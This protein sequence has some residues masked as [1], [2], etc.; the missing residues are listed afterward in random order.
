MRNLVQELI[1]NA[2]KMGLYT[3][4]D[5]PSDKLRNALSDYAKSV[6]QEEVLALY[7]ATLLGNAKDG[8]V[9]TA[10]RL[11][12]QNNNLEP[13]QTVRYEDIIHVDT[14]RKLL[15]GRQINLDV[16]R[17]RAT[18]TLTLDFSAKAAA[19]EYVARFLQEALHRSVAAEMDT[20][21]AAAQRTPS[22][23][24]LPVIEQALDELRSSGSLTT[25][26]HERILRVLRG[27]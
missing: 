16:N 9:F 21:P 10:D 15:G 8:A 7:D 1:P 17:G 6:H 24:N 2:P 20:P 5:I 12:F 13:A 14:R 18:V 27:H 23:S 19:A 3:R 4:P 11:V 25:E 26:D 22:G